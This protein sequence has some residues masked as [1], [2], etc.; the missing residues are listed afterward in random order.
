MPMFRDIHRQPMITHTSDSH[1]VPSQN[2]IKSKL[3]KLPKYQILK[4]R[5]KLY[6]RDIF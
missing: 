1:Q 5:N 3:Q 2:K 6:K 4:F